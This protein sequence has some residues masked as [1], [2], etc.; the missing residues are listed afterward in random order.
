[1]IKLNPSAITNSTV[2][3]SDVILTTSQGTLKIK[4]GKNKVITFVDDNGAIIEKIYYGNISYNPL[5][6]GLTYDSK[7]IMLTVSS[8]FADNAID[9]GNYLSTVTK[10][11]G[12]AVSKAL[13]I[14]GNDLANSIKG[15]KGADTI[16]GG[17]GKDTIFGGNGN[18]E[19]YGDSENDVLKGEAGN[20]TLFGGA[21]ND[22]L[23]GGVGKDIFIYESG[24]DVITDYKPSDDM[25]KLNPSA[26]TNSTVKGS[27]VVL[28][29]ANGNLTVK[30]AKDKV[31]TFIDDNG[32][33]TEKIYYGNIFYAPLDTGLTYDSKKTILTAGSKFSE[34]T[35]DLG[36]YLDTVK[37]VNASS[38]KQAV[39]IIGNDNNNSL[40]GGK[41]ADTI[42]GGA[43]NDT[44]TGGSGKDIFVYESG[45]DVITDYKSSE[46]TIQI[47]EEITNTSYSGK[48][49][50]FTIGNGSLTVKNAKGKDI[51]VKTGEQ[52]QTFSFLYDN[53]FMTDEFQLDDISAISDTNYSVGQMEFEEENKFSTDTLV[54]SAFEKK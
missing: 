18:D 23:T 28:T 36:N 19:I 44:L 21:G 27:N 50:I 10:L 42:S 34:G 52:I 26:I 37:K 24:N 3:G 33:T 29:T 2:K 41:G 5:A 20:D 49:V 15:G 1:M 11:N 12:G 31:I 43:G 32:N 16:Y 35:I 48:N 6:T 51:S 46:D 25:I 22:T 40:K 7:R 39:E 47:S 38:I 8:K 14:S 54:S 17:A 4:G 13:S 53:N 30:S 45:N 9:L